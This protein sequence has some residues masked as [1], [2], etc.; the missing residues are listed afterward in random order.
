MRFPRFFVVY[1]LIGL[2]SVRNIYK[3]D[4][5][6][7]IYDVC[8]VGLR[9]IQTFCTPISHSFTRQDTRQIKALSNGEKP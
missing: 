1:L 8:H 5:C 7:I 4:A 2:I 3:Y 9:F 6:H